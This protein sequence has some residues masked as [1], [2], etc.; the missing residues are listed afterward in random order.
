MENTTPWLVIVNP[1]AGGSKA[2][3][4]WPKISRL[5]LEAGF[6]FDVYFSTHPHHIIDLVKQLIETK[7]YDKIVAV[8]GDGTLNEVVN[9]VFKQT[10]I[11]PDKVK[12]GLITIGTG[13]DWGRMYEM[14]KSYQKQ[15]KILLKQHTI[16]QDVGRVSYLHDT[17]SNHRY[18]VNIAG[19]GFDALVAKKTNLLK[20]RGS[21]GPL[22]YL[23][24]LVTGL[25][26]FHPVHVTLQRD[27]EE[28]FSGSVFS[29]SIG[30]CKFN[31]GGMKQLPNAIPNDGLFDVT[32]IKKMRKSKV[33]R[34]IH[35]VYDGSFIHLKEV[36]TFTGK[37]FT[38]QSEPAHKAF[39]ETDGESLGHSPLFFEILPKAIT[40]II[41][42]KAA[43]QYTDSLTKTSSK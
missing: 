42:K 7:N 20:I 10:R 5:L 33:L 25:F 39:L 12:V 1:H 14:P 24:S 41:K 8:G 23:Y 27:D 18:F 43:K 17:L 13:N 21:G 34:H 16:L 31:G 26:Q 30:I 11:S 4:D 38:I 29:M 32:I 19:M 28:V 36:A 37:S 15:I 9:G 22:S 40:L 35:Q 3:S 6:Q 2:K